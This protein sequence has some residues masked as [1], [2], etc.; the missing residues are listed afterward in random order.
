MD[1]QY[2]DT[3]FGFVVILLAVSLLISILTQIISS[4]LALRGRNLMWGVS[5]L[6]KTAEPKL[7]KAE[8]VAKEVLTHSALSDSI[9]SEN[10]KG[11]WFSWLAERFCL[12]KEHN[13]SQGQEQKKEQGH[14]YLWIA[15]WLSNWKLAAVVS[16]E[17]LA[18]CLRK[19][20]D[21]KLK[22]KSF[23]SM[24][25]EEKANAVGDEKDGVL[26]RELL[27]AV[28]PDA[29]RKAQ[30]VK[31]VLKDLAPKYAVQVDK[32]VQQLGTSVSESVGKL[33]AWFNIIMKR[34]AQRFAM[35]TRIWTIVFA[36]IVSLLANLDAFKIWNQLWTT[37]ILRANIVKIAPDLL[38]EASSILSD[39]SSTAQ[40]PAL[41]V[42]SPKVLHDAMENLVGKYKQ[43][44]TDIGTI[45]N[46]SS[47]DEAV[48]WL[49]THLKSDESSQERRIAEYKF[50][51]A[52]TIRQQLEGT[53]FHLIP[54]PVSLVSFD[55]LMNILGV[56]I[57]V[58]FLSLGAPFWYNVL[59]NLA[60]LRS[61]I[62]IRQE[63]QRKSS[64]S[65]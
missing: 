2:L 25:D 65:S 32:I 33:D 55:G 53:G 13:T 49:R 50:L 7:E 8:E 21:G 17:S 14:I 56:L 12:P 46:F 29:A 6:L 5:T 16:P 43:D 57:F 10:H 41:T 51:L 20:A 59:K 61:M 23:E 62:S 58:G 15:K 3:I 11:A 39:Q 42:S 60:N 18:R 64:V 63:E 40:V 48:K 35:H 1:L 4:V 36:I 30:A 37:P 22:N 47:L 38:K 52:D 28:D 54:R 31:I 24:T 9:F 44:M 45:P 27:N 19:V 34:T 26:I